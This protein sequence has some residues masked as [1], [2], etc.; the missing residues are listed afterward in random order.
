MTHQGNQIAVVWVRWASEEKRSKPLVSGK[1]GTE[2]SRA[3]G[4][5]QPSLQGRWATGFRKPVFHAQIYNVLLHLLLFYIYV[6][7][8]LKM[9]FSNA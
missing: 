6:L 8:H 5:S 4:Q 2:Q 7:W 1:E 9:K 3:G